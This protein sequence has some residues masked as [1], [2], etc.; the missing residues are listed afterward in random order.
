[1]KAITPEHTCSRSGGG[2]AVR[3][4]CQAPHMQRRRASVH[5]RVAPRLT[6][7]VPVQVPAAPKPRVLLVDADNATALVVELLL[8]PEVIVTHVSSLAAARVA[9][10]SSTFSLAVIDPALHDGDAVDLLPSLRAAQ[11][12][13][14]AEHEPDW[15]VPRRGFL[16]KHTSSPRQLYIAIA[17]MLGLVGGIGAGD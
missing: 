12:L 3:P 15:R 5:A 17:G 16:P 1:M 8:S 11:L 13:V 2:I 7:P 14:Y 4:A 10:A 9:L 6:A